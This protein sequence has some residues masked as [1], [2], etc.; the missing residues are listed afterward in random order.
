M[1]HQ[2]STGFLALVDDARGRIRET[3]VK[4]IRQRMENG[5]DMRLI[6]VREDNELAAGRIPGAEHIG[7]GVLERD[8]ESKLPDHDEEIVL[9][10]GGGFRSALAADNLQKMGYTNVISMDGGFRAWRENGFPVEGTS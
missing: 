7:R 6:D 4:T 1:A 9:Y 10:C 2:H 5:E 3:D 8:A